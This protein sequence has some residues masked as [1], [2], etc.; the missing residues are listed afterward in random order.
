[1]PIS[2]MTSN[3]LEVFMISLSQEQQV[4]PCE[5]TPRFEPA[6]SIHILHRPSKLLWKYE[7]NILAALRFH[8][9]KNGLWRLLGRWSM[10]FMMDKVLLWI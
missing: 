10:R 3:L 2:V 1:M 9:T 7:L 5:R 8:R 4:A 6:S